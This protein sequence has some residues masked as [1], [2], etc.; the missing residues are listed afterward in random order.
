MAYKGCTHS[1]TNISLYIYNLKY[2][3]PSDF[4]PVISFQALENI[5]TEKCK[6][7][8]DPNGFCGVWCTWWVYHRMKNPKVENKLLA[9]GLIQLIKLENK[10]FKTLIRNFSY[11]IVEIRDK[12]LKKFNIDIND[13][14]VSNVSNETINDLEKEILKL[15]T[16]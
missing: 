14:M 10:S 3:K 8:G 15:V 5:A 16:Y 6:K 12:T 13:W 1:K 9:E 11:Y 4:L 2:I 7:I